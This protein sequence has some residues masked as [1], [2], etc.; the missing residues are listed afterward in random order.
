MGSSALHDELCKQGQ[1][2]LKKTIGARLA[3]SE[4]VCCN[5]YG[6]IPDVIGWKG[7]YSILIEC[8]TSRSD[9]KVDAK[10]IFRQFPEFGMGTFRLYLCPDGL[11][12]PEELPEGWGLLYY[13]PERKT[14]KRVECFKGNIV[15]ESGNLKFQASHFKSER[16]LLLSYVSRK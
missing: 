7:G 8:K 16:D 15:M 9:F 4:M 12:K 1:R 5:T 6:E 11:I 14:L 10:K 2:W 13:S 3:I